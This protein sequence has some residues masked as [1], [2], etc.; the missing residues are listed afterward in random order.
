MDILTREQLLA[1]EE[2]KRERVDFEDGKGSVFVRMMTGR[3]R[4]RFEQSLMREE[5]D[6]KG[7]VTYKRALE[8]FRAKLAVNTVCDETG[9]NIF[10]P[11]DY[12]ELSQ[13][14][15]AARLKQIADAAGRLN[16]ITEEEGEDL[17]KNSESGQNESDTSESGAAM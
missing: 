1:K 7:R 8:D 15:G 12:D 14:M 17:V 6:K 3:E 2:L 4:D 11:Q 10:Q 5:T 16:K 9:K 13:N